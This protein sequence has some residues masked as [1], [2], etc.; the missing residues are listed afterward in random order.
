VVNVA[1]SGLELPAGVLVPEWLPAVV[2][3]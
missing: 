1:Q 2:I 3:A